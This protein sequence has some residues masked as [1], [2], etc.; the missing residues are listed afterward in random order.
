MR[1]RRTDAVH[2]ETFPVILCPRTGTGIQDRERPFLHYT[3][4]LE[5]AM[6]LCSQGNLTDRIGTGNLKHGHGHGM[7]CDAICRD[8]KNVNV[9]QW[10]GWEFRTPLHPCERP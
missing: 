6:A 2:L 3:E 10:S 7:H 9:N 4:L 8:V 1:E 5:S